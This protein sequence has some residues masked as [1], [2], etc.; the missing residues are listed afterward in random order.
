MSL[1]KKDEKGVTIRNKGHS[2]SKVLEKRETN[3]FIEICLY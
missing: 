1:L 3:S 2:Q